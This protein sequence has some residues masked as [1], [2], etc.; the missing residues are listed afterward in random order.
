MIK[1]TLVIALSLSLGGRV[2]YAQPALNNLHTEIEVVDIRRLGDPIL[3]AIAAEVES[4]V[5]A[6]FANHQRRLY[7]TLLDFRR[8]NNFGR[9]ISAPQNGVLA[10]DRAIDK[11]SVVTRE[12]YLAMPDYFRQQ[13]DYVIDAPNA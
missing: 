7:A 1:T 12:T 9:A 5:D 13:V 10:I 3:Q 6:D 8:R 11:N 2:L 4:F